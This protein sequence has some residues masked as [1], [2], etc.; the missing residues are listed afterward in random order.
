M[1]DFIINTDSVLS[2]FLEVLPITIIV[3][4]IYLII[5]YIKIKNKKINY[6]KEIIYF[7]FVCYIT[8]LINLILV[9]SNL[10][11]NIFYYIK[12]KS[13]AGNLGPFLTF[14]YNLKST[15]Y[16]TLKEE[17]LLGPWAMTMLLGNTL[18]FIPLGIFIN[19]LNK[20]LSNIKVILIS[21]FLPITIEIIQ[22]LIGRSFDIDDIITNIL[23]I[24]I[25]YYLTKLI[26][27]IIKK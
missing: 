14:D 20:K 2:E 19:L 13:F 23:G 4:I 9:P 7:L 3:G 24:L 17:F 15:I 27:F 5:R 21:V 1:I 22:P 8:G 18:M 10:W 12:N 26:R 6:K 11:Y 25:G 16:L